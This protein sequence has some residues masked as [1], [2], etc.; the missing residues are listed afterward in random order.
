MSF[1]APP[2]P[3]FDGF[4]AAQEYLRTEFGRD[5]QFYGTAAATYP[6]T[7]PTAF[8]DEGIPLDPLATTV[9]TAASV[10]L[11]NLALLGVARAVVVFRPLQTSI[12]RRDETF[13]TPLGI[14]SGLNK[15]LI[16]S[17]ADASLAQSATHFMIGTANSDGTFTPQD[18][19]LWEIVNIK[20]DSFGSVERLVVYGEG[21]R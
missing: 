1:G 4:S 12:M 11:A 8:D 15:D 3:N 20:N 5:V 21:T 10:E 2:M 17:A 14:R 7:P 18:G 19:E 6:T 16:M 9:E 13:E